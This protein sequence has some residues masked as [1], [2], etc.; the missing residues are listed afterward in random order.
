[1]KVVVI[2]PNQKYDCIANHFIEGLYDNGIDVIASDLGN[3][4]R[5]VC[6]KINF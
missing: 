1:M 6:F 4:V 3:S 2:S 5:K